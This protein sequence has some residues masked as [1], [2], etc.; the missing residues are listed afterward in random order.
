MIIF[1]QN[2]FER[3]PEKITST[4]NPRIKAVLELQQKAQARR[5]QQL[6]VVEGARE[7]RLALASGCKPNALFVCTERLQER[8]EAASSRRAFAPEQTTEVSAHVFERLA[9][10]EDSD[11][12]MAL[13]HPLNRHLAALEGDPAPLFIVLEAVEKPGNLGAILRTADA[14]GVSGVLVCD[15]R[16]D[17]YNP[18]TIR[19]SVGCVFTV[20]VVPCTSAEAI[21]WLKKNNVR[22]LTAALNA[23]RFYHECNLRGAAALVMGT[24]A[25]G[26]TEQWLQ[27]ADENIMIPMRGMI[28]SLNVSVSTAILVFEAMRQRGFRQKNN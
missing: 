6:I 26:L 5:T 28:D 3:M 14:A 7:I 21:H 16:A 25:T 9:Y 4:A 10:R 12:M 22:I 20:P 8:E 13:L 24:E 1:E 23:Q 18:N 19:S 11:G 15:P 27:A 17:I 2:N